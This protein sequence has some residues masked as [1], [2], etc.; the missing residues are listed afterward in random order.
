MEYIGCEG[1]KTADNNI[2]FLQLEILTFPN[3]SAYY[4]EVLKQQSTYFGV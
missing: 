4:W 3:L 2:F 1:S